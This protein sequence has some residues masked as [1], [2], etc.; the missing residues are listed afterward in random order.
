M[1]EVY[2]A[3]DTRLGR[4]IAL[5]LLPEA[6]ASE[7]ER[8]DRFQRE[9][10]ALAALEHPNIVTIHSV[11]EAGGR[12]FL[13]MQLVRGRTLTDVR[14]ERPVSLSALL[15]IAV[16]LAG[17]LEAAHGRGI[18]HRDLKPDNVMLTEDGRV[19]VL[20]FGLAKQTGPDVGASAEHT[21][22]G[23][24]SGVVMGTAAYMSPEQVMGQP[25]DHRSDIFSLGILIHELAT[26]RR[27]FAADNHALLASA[28]LR[29]DPPA[30]TDADPHWPAA[31]A[32]VVLTCLKKDPAH[33]FQS[34]TGVSDAIRA[35]RAVGSGPAV[36][37]PAV[38][39]VVVLPFAN[40]SGDPDNEYFSDGLTEEVI[41]DLSRVAA[42]RIISRN[43]S[44][45]LKGTTKN[46]ATLARELGV[47]HLVT[48]SVRRAGTALRVTTELVDA[49]S[50]APIWSDK[51][52]GTTDDV[53]AIQEEI[54][55]R[56][57]AALEV[58]LT[59]AE[60]RQI[61]ERPIA[62]A[63]AYDCYLRARRE[64]YG[65]TPESAVRAHQL[66]DEA[67]AIVG[68][69]PLLLATKGFLHWN[70]VNTNRV[71][72]VDG[73]GQASELAARALALDPHLALAIFVRG[74]VAGLRGQPEQA[75]PDLYRAHAL[76]PNDPNIM[77]EVARFSNAAGLR[78]H[79]G[80]I[81]RVVEIDPLTPT[82][83]LVQATHSYVDGRFDLVAA[84]ARRGMKLAPAPSMLHI[85]LGWFLES[86]GCRV[87][88]IDALRRTADAHAGNVLGAWASFHER[89]LA[90][91][92][93]GALAYGAR[94]LHALQNEWAR[95]LVAEGY[96]LLGHADEAVQWARS[97]V[98]L[99]FVNYPFMSEHSRHF[100]SLRDHPPFRELLDEVRPRWQKLIAWEEQH[101]AAGA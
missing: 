88:A 50:D 23:T 94:L 16:Q 36:A 75:L 89:A 5:K 62:D 34:M 15:D 10:R 61:A 13:T 20:D 2:R 99:G 65:W 71:A 39:T 91:D 93:E 37:T 54:A 47:S 1:G 79:A 96:A 6:V 72:A 78:H 86:A 74:A 24:Q 32:Q 76:A 35:V 9:A 22:L 14:R 49:R 56:I 53:F 55:R 29:D 41:A 67:L 80:L 11:E 44:M 57:V 64:M 28:I 70:D 60:S 7:P 31:L 33:R 19:K 90:G 18:V 87:E 26:D 48:G 77:L 92:E 27:P 66:V 101:P 42:L 40:R 17:A 63:V 82:T 58:A 25:L 52:S 3:V 84:P 81:Q 51:Y 21:A 4:D 85:L 43:S 38:K 100:A 73:L 98:E 46:S 95:I 69:V 97:A 59:D 12:H 8:L 68:D 45:T 83:P 30:L